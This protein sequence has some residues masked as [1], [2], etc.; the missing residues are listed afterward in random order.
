MS[1]QKHPGGR[2]TKYKPEYC[3]KVV[4]H[5]KDGG[6]MHEFA[7]EIEV[8]ID[9]LYEWMKVHEEFSEAVKK[10]KSFSQ[11]WWMGIARRSLFTN[12]FNHVLWYM[13]MKNRFG[14]RDKQEVE[15]TGGITVSFDRDDEN[16]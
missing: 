10:G 5:M 15:H 3:D 2:P 13:N 12:N 9:T 11:G 8:H 14:W 1:D 16:L 4:A 6:S 7:R